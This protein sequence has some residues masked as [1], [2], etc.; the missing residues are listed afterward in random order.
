MPSF[1]PIELFWQHGKQFVSL[2]YTTMR[3]IDELW[4]QV[5]VKGWQGDPE[6]DGETGAWKPADFTKLV[7]HAFEEIHTWIQN[8]AVLGCTIRR[9][10]L[11]QAYDK[12]ATNDKVVSCVGGIGCRWRLRF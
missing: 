8:D 9:L 4:D 11:P 2:R 6:W 1:D 12:G 5:S 10:V 7:A 3:R